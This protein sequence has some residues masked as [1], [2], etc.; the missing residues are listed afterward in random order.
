M[1][2]DSLE[3]D[4]TR[5]IGHKYLKSED[6]QKILN[7]DMIAAAIQR[8]KKKIPTFEDR[9]EKCM[10]RYPSSTVYFVV[11]DIIDI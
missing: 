4:L 11:Q 2:Q 7:G 1:T 6:L 8:S 9:I 10:K 5:A 3:E